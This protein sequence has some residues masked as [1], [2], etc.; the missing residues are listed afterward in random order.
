MASA[1]TSTPQRLFPAVRL[2]RLVTEAQLHQRRVAYQPNLPLRLDLA[3]P[4]RQHFLEGADGAAPS[5]G[6]NV[7][8]EDA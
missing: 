2:S 8:M 3:Q 6:L 4:A 1:T 5:T 7:S